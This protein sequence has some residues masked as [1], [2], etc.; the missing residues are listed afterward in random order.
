MRL[1]P[2]AP[3]DLYDIE[4]AIDESGDDIYLA[5]PWLERGEPIL[6]Q[7][8][9][10]L[11]DVQRFGASG[12]SYH[13]TVSHNGEFVGIIALDYTPHLIAGHWNLGYWIRPSFQ[14]RGIANKSID[15]VLNWIGRG[16]LTSVEINV[17]PDNVASVRTAES[18]VQRWRGH[19]FE[20]K[21]TKEVAG[22]SVVHDIWLIPRLP[23][24]DER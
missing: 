17:N 15:G 9:A 16:G 21:Y 19:L 20:K 6:P 5:M 23:L 4:E 8:E 11:Q 3:H 14:R 1:F 18:V 10:Y 7:V 22:Q 2:A 24:E 12:F 13:W